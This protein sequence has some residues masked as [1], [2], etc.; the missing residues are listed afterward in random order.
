M[1]AIGKDLLYSFRRNYSRC[2]VPGCER[3]FRSGLSLWMHYAQAHPDAG[4][5]RLPDSKNA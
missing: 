1:T 5:V 2:V 4:I 3:R